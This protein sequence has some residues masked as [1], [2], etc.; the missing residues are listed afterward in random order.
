[1]EKV[2]L[3]ELQQKGKALASKLFVYAKDTTTKASK[4][5]A[6]VKNAVVEN[7]L[8]GELDRE[9]EAFAAELA[10]SRLP[11]V[12]EPWDGLPDRD[13][14]KKKILALSLDH[15]NFIRESPGECEFDEAT[16][17]AMAKRLVEVDPNLS[18]VRFE[19]VPKQLNEEKF[20]HNYF[21]RV[22][23]IRQSLMTNA[24]D[25]QTPVRKASPAPIETPSSS[26]VDKAST[27]VSNPEPVIEDTAH[28]DDKTPSD[29]TNPQPEDDWEREILS[30]LNEYE[31]VAS[32]NEKS[33]EQWEAEIQDL[34]NS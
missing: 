25:V 20:W 4:G 17:Q 19:L 29:E 14:A 31:L 33:E 24:S 8:I 10:A 30:D 27:N 1:M 12:V 23:L 2:S 9:Q 7:T 3:E 6:A 5:I 28:G 13:F 26:E 21:Y 18:R 32:R 16:M 34:L 11:D 15:H 22:S